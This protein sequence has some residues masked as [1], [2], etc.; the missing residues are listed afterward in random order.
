MEKVTVTNLLP[1]SNYKV[2]IFASN[3]YGNSNFSEEFLFRTWPSRPTKP[4]DVK[5]NFHVNDNSSVSALISWKAPCM[6]NGKFSLYTI[7]IN[8]NRRGLE[9]YKETF[10]STISEIEVHDLSEG[11]KYEIEIQAVNQQNGNINL[12]GDVLK[13]S[14]E[15]PS[16]SENFIAIFYRHFLIFI[17]VQF[18]WKMT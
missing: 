13:Q 5:V 3:K 7:I 10:A 17:S 2:K 16:G 18:H 14:F 8:G 1:F 15:A 9:N 12:S 4:R 11:F 6:M